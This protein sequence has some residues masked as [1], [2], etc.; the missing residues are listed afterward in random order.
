MNKVRLFFLIPILVFLPLVSF[1]E[2]EQESVSLTQFQSPS[3]ASKILREQ[4][5]QSFDI[6]GNG[7]VDDNDAQSILLNSVGLIDSLDSFSSSLKNSLL[8]E[9][10]LDKFSYTGTVTDGFNYLSEKV[11]INVEERAITIDNVPVVYY[12][13][14]IY[15]RDIDCLRTA[16]A[17]EDYSRKSDSVEKMAQDNHALIAVSGDYYAA[18]KKGLVIRNGVVYRDSF[19]SKRDSCVIYK[20][21]TMEM[22]LAKE[23]DLSYVLSKD[24]YQAWCFGPSLLDADGKPKTRFNTSVGNRN[25]RCSIGYYEPGHYCFVVVDG[26]SKR[27]SFGIDMNHLS[28]LFYELGC[29]AAYNLDGGATAI[30]VTSKEC[31]SSQSDKSRGCSDILYIIDP[32]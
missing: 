17:Y 8:G 29:T 24:P 22:F 23:G 5:D 1:A 7:I 9:K 30:M 16:F 21:G 31:I 32:K 13:A 10:Y 19:S 12:I 2:N 25:P 4:S 3:E 18:R 14:D 11:H 26:R 6:T 27:H 28:Q 15:I 20:D